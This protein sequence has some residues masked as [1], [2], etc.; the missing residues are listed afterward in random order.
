MILPPESTSNC[1]TTHYKLIIRAVL[2]PS[3]DYLIFKVDGKSIHNFTAESEIPTNYRRNFYFTATKK[4]TFEFHSGT[5]ATPT[6]PTDNWHWF[7][8]ID[9]M[10]SPVF[11][12]VILNNI[13]SKHVLWLPDMTENQA[14]IIQNNDPTKILKMYSTFTEYSG[15]RNFAIY[16]G[17]NLD[18]FI[19]T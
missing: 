19:Q 2:R 15:L 10:P 8:R 5:S 18:N 14:I 3:I 9:P 6:K 17:Q 12:S 4:Y 1:P 11:D 7:V 13:S 16:D